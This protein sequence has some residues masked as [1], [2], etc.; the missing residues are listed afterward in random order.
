MAKKKD[1]ISKPS[2]EVTPETAEKLK[3]LLVKLGIQIKVVYKT[4][5][6][7][8][9]KKFTSK[10]E[11]QLDKKLEKHIDEKCK[12]AKWIRGATKILEIMGL[13]NII[14]ADLIYIQDGKFPEGRERTK[15]EELDILNRARKLLK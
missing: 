13:K 1:K 11:K 3:P 5:C 2:T 4:E 12:A 15:P 7:L 6:E 9:G 14:F 8:C 10:D